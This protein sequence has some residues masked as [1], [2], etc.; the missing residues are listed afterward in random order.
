MRDIKFRAWDTIN[1]VWIDVFELKIGQSGEV[2]AIAA[3]DGE[4]Y[5]L[6]QVKLVQFTGLCDKEGVEIYE[7]DILHGERT[8]GIR[9]R[10]GY[11]T[12][13]FI[14]YSRHGFP[15]AGIYHFSKKCIVIGN[16][17]E[18]LELLRNRK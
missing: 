9:H 15:E 8:L 2:M 16:I 7:G 1:K 4:L 14:C 12:G 6:H 3:L 18:N 13:K 17:Y 10:V 11:T 5:G